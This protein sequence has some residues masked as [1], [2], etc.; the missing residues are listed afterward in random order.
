MATG[1]ARGRWSVE[2][3]ARIVTQSPC[4]VKRPQGIH[5]ASRRADHHVDAGKIGSAN[6]AALPGSAR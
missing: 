6:A 2:L 1:T 4:L 3:I 5:D